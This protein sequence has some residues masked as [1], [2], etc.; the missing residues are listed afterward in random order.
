MK[1]AIYSDL[2]LEMAPFVPP[3]DLAADVVVL[4]GDINVGTRGIEWA[5][6]TFGSR[7]IVYVHGNHE[8]YGG[9]LQKVRAEAAEMAA[10]HDVHLLDP[11]VVVIDG[12]RF[13]GCTLW[14]GFK[15]RVVTEA[16]MRSDPVLAS[17]VADQQMNDYHRIRFRDGPHG[18]IY[19]RLRPLDTG[20]EFGLQAAWLY[21]RLEEPFDGPTAA[22]VVASRVRVGPAVSGV[23]QRV[24]SRGRLLRGAEAVGP[25]AYAQQLRLRGR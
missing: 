8:F 9:V 6:K 1:I 24:G 14:T 7:P 19:R 3:E 11:G 15:L 20:R 16:G 21:M 4:A 23:R 22:R 5:R 13:V 18:E 10:I 17:A 12:V 25:R 2:H